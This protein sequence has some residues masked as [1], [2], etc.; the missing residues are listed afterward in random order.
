VIVVA[1]DKRATGIPMLIV[2]YISRYPSIGERIAPVRI[3]DKSAIV[4]LP[5]RYTVGIR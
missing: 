5:P 4:D 2:R 3:I 1:F